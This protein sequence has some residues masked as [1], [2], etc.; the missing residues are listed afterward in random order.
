MKKIGIIG[1]GLS[2]LYAAVLLEK[3]YDITLFEARDR[4]GGRI[5]TIDGFDLGPSWIWPHQH[6]ILK[7]I[8]SLGLGIIPQYSK[9]YA[10][11]QIPQKIEKFFQPSVPSWR[12]QGGMDTLIQSLAAKIRQSKIVLNTPVEVLRLDGDCV[13]IQ[14]D[15]TSECFDEVI[16]TLPPRLF[17]KSLVLDPPL[18][19]LTFKSLEN[20]P[21]WMGHSAKCVI[22]FETPFWRKVGLSG[23]CFSHSGPMGEIH[24]ACSE[25]RYALFGFINSNANMK[26]IEEDVRLQCSILFGDAGKK[27]I[28]FYCIDWRNEKYTSVSDDVLSPRSHPNYGFD[29]SHF[30]GKVHFIGTE[31]SYEEGGYLEGA[32]A[33]V[34][35]LGNELLIDA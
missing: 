30:G 14:T 31:S 8:N 6:R 34:E 3:E 33:S 4:L 18:D 12:I 22:E 17:L 29:L 16:V 10:L 35:K 5:F 21:T 32:I 26:T 15:S 25:K 1:G 27:I 28:N 2:G 9:G 7:L 20:I 23:F 13:V 11:Y 24:D 19:H